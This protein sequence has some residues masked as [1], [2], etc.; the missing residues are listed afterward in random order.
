[1]YDTNLRLQVKRDLRPLAKRGEPCGIIEDPNNPGF[2]FIGPL[3]EIG[4]E[5]LDVEGNI[6]YNGNS[7]CQEYT[8]YQGRNSLNQLNQMNRLKM[9]EN[10]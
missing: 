3:C 10:R 5:C 2:A 4:F 1:M 7:Y 9:A 6:N 8:V